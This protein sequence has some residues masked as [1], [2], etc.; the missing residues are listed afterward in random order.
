MIPHPLF[1]NPV[2]LESLAPDR[3]LPVVLPDT[4]REMDALLRQVFELQAQRDNMQSALIDQIHAR[5]RAE[6]RAEK[7][8]KVVAEVLMDGITGLPG[9]YLYTTTAQEY[10]AKAKANP[11]DNLH[12][13]M[14]DLDGLKRVN[15]TYGHGAGNQLLKL[16]ANKANKYFRVTSDDFAARLGGDEFAILFRNVMSDGPIQRKMRAFQAE[17]STWQ[18]RVQDTKGAWHMLTA[19]GFSYGLSSLKVRTPEGYVTRDINMDEL[20]RDADG[21]MYQDKQ[22]RKGLQANTV[23]LAPPIG[24]AI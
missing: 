10:F 2:P 13:C 20:G 1:D 21:L 19:E 16:F 6:A 7:A 8:E 14:I 18:F 4:A 5:Q 15:D 24:L 17:A 12:V 9:L 3:M 22:I 23:V 11:N